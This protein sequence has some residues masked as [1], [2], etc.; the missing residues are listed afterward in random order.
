MSRNCLSTPKIDKATM[1][2]DSIT[3]F[4][5]RTWFVKNVVE[6]CILDIVVL[7]VP[8]KNELVIDVVLIT[9]QEADGQFLIE[10]ITY[11]ASWT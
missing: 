8:N 7:W 1:L 10:N 3:L 4:L 9:V 2:F 6:F 11:Y 5:L